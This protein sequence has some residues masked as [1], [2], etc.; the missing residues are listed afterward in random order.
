MHNR[1]VDRDFQLPARI[2]V[3]EIVALPILADGEV[4]AGE[5]GLDATVVGVQVVPEG[6]REF[7]VEPRTVLIVDASRVA[8]DTYYLDLV[9][10]WAAESSAAG[11]IVTKTK[12]PVGLAPRRLAQRFSL[13]LISCDIDPFTLIDSIRELVSQPERFLAGLLL[14]ALTQLSRMNPVEGLD[15]VLR[16]LDSTLDSRSSVVSIDGKAVVGAHLYP[17]LSARERIPV[18]SVSENESRLT[19][20]IQPIQLASGEP[21]SFWLVTERRSPTKYWL[22]AA[23]LILRVASQYLALA[24]VSER[25][26]RERDARFSLGLLNAVMAA[27]QASPRLV[28]QVGTLGW[29]VEGWC[30]AIHIHFT[31]ES[32][33]WKMLAFTSELREVFVQSGIVGALIER[34]DGWTT[35]AV[36][37][38]EPKPGAFRE[39]ADRVR[40]TLRRFFGDHQTMRISA[41]VGRP[42]PGLAGLRRSLAEAHE[43]A[44][45]SQ[46]SGA[47][48]SVQHADELGVERVLTNWYASSEFKEFATTL[49]RPLIDS[50]DGELVHTLEVYLDSESSPTITADLL[51]VHRNTI[52][53][54]LARIRES[55]SIDFEN[56]DQR[57]V[58]QLACRAVNLRA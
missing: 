19:R 42:Y 40:R 8:V 43:A 2:S 15:G 18:Y 35:W 38:R 14:P 33:Q 4:L 29:R 52:M 26:E 56:A 37:E 9:L 21:P 41:G 54:R 47:P 1:R 22:R 53:N 49:L 7:A 58:V 27:E 48:F 51:G 30:S 46:A 25:L 12:E 24:L 11:V 39:L 28:Q 17:P 6:R 16:I 50:G 34:P 45:I 10:R 57:L 31:G 32:E 13:P 5:R 55:L 36:S 3:R 20:A 23:S 44:T